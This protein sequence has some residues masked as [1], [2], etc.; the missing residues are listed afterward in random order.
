MDALAGTLTTIKVNTNELV[1]KTNPDSR[2]SI[3]KSIRSQEPSSAPSIA[4][5]TAFLETRAEEKLVENPQKSSSPWVPTPS[6]ETVAA[7]KVETKD[8]LAKTPQAGGSI[9][10]QNIA[11]SSPPKQH[12]AKLEEI[13]LKIPQ[14]GGG[15]T[16][17]AK[18]TAESSTLQPSLQQE[19]PQSPQ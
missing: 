19:G 3:I 9:I 16:S 17:R 13:L 14:T 1:V 12:K 18:E 6:T 2:G 10:N 7:Q 8:L 11:D 4:P 5:D 15:N